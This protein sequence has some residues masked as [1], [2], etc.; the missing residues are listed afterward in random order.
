MC[1]DV[2]KKI[3]VVEN[4]I[5]IQ[6][7]ISNV[8][9]KEFPECDLLGNAT[10]LDEMY[11]LLSLCK[12]DI[13]IAN[14]DILKGEIQEFEKEVE[15]VLLADKI[16]KDNIAFV[17]KRNVFDVLMDDLSASRIKD[18]IDRLLECI[19]INDIELRRKMNLMAYCMNNLPYTRQRVLYDLIV[20]NYNNDEEKIKEDLDRAYL[21]L[22]E[23][24]IILFSLRPKG[25]TDDEKTNQTLVNI[26]KRFQSEVNEMVN[27]YHIYVDMRNLAIIFK[28]ELECFTE[29]HLYTFCKNTVDNIAKN[30]EEFF[31]NVAISSKGRDINEAN[32][33]YFECLREMEKV[34]SKKANHIFS[35]SRVR[36]IYESHNFRKRM[37][38][39][40][41]DLINMLSME[42]FKNAEYYMLKIIEE[43]ANIKD[44]WG[45]ADRFYTH[46]LLE[47]DDIR[48]ELSEDEDFGEVNIYTLEQMIGGCSKIEDLNDILRM[49]VKDLVEK[50]QK[51][52]SKKYSNSVSQAI[53]FIENNYNKA[54]T[55]EDVAAQIHLSAVHVSRIFNNETG[56]SIKS[57]LNKLRIKK[58][59]SLLMTGKF[60]INEVAVK[61]GFEDSR[62]FSTVFKKYEG[63]S[64][65]DYIGNTGN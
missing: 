10:D 49:T 38:M 39:H 34:G 15:F 50:I 45:F 31:I 47:L 30:N 18:S 17:L 35:V 54:I 9:I 41:K 44:E 14:I 57:Y 7:I 25:E 8:I 37:I 16:D 61:V 28:D 4:R 42:D 59:K 6:Q 20:G 32:I 52:R 24:Y 19:K 21:E 40:R 64:P 5:P 23:F 33:R 60:R 3:I 29:K 55:L 43:S 63:I 53:E 48:R 1:E 2:M 36:K 27:V 65:T 58:A 11:K 56:E 62:Y 26:L 13:V 12:P 22:S 46:L 51:E